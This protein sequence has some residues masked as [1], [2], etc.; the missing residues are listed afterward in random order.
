MNVYV[1]GLRISPQ[2]HLF[3]HQNQGPM[4]ICL[5]K[6]DRHCIAQFS[7]PGVAQTHR[8]LILASA[9][10]ASALVRGPVLGLE[11]ELELELAAAWQPLAWPMP[12]YLL[13]E[14]QVQ[15]QG[16]GRGRRQAQRQEMGRPTKWQLVQDCQMDCILLPFP[17]RQPSPDGRLH[18]QNGEGD[19]INKCRKLRSERERQRDRKTGKRKT[20][21]RKEPKKK[22]KKHGHGGW[23][24]RRRSNK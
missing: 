3:H 21:Y 8:C 14:A 10:E 4:L 9:R 7:T 24:V 5:N 13:L 16:R 18:E 15:V 2:S 11:L 17:L 19:I 23:R 6:H 1:E 20:T 12:G 22:K